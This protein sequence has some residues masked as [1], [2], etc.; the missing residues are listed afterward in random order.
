MKLFHENKTGLNLWKLN[1]NIMS[2]KIFIALLKQFSLIDFIDFYIDFVIVVSNINLENIYTY[3]YDFK[4]LHFKFFVNI[5]N[6][7]K[8][9]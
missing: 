4:S 5:S 2:F 8:T 1:E 7:K 6:R 9:S 3:N